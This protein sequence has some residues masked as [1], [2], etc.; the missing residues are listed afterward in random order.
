[1][2]DLVGLVADFALDVL[3]ECLLD[4]QSPESRFFEEF[5]KYRKLRNEFLLLL[6][7]VLEPN[8][9]RTKP[10]DGAIISPFIPYE[11][12]SSTSLCLVRCDLPP[13]FGLGRSFQ[14][15]ERSVVGLVP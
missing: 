10:F 8:A 14:T 9:A 2:L 12:S 13:R 11:N 15:A 6:F 4:K 1:M 3:G 5:P 7:S